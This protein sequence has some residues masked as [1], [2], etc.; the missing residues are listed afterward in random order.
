MI[1][2]GSQL[3]VLCHVDDVKISHVDP[4]VVSNFIQWMRSQYEGTHG[5]W[6]LSEE[7]GYCSLV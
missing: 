4:D 3:T 2:N 6:K 5:K 1:V 7:K